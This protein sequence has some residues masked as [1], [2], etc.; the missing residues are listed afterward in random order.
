MVV[1]CSTMTA[2]NT[3]EE[4]GKITINTHSGNQKKWFP[5]HSPQCRSNQTRLLRTSFDFVEPIGFKFFGEFCCF[6]MRRKIVQICKIKCSLFM[7]LCQQL[8]YPAI[9]QCKID[10]H[11]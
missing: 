6:E 4:S 2:C 9:E 5:S 8:T 10:D 3:L 11:P 1:R 7:T